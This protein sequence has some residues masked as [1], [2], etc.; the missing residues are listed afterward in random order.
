MPQV[1]DGKPLGENLTPANMFAVLT[2]LGCFMLLPF[3]LAIEGQTTTDYLPY[4][5]LPCLTLPYLT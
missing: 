4:L 5:A 2:I 3:S 1:L